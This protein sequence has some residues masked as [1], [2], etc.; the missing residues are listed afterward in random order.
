M[1][2]RQLFICSVQGMNNQLKGGRRGEM[3]QF[4]QQQKN[5]VV[6]LNFFF[7]Q[8]NVLVMHKKS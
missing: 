1:D 8:E 3:K 5:S 6:F 2:S 7:F 4:Q